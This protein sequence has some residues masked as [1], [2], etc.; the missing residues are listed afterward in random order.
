MRKIKTLI[1][2]TAVI[3]MTAA[4]LVSAAPSPVAGTVTVIVPG[5]A[6]EKPA[7]VKTPTEKELKE[8]AEFISENA[9][10]LGMSASVKSTID[11]VAP[12]DYKGGDT[13][14]VFAVSGLKDGAKNV[15]AYILLKNGK[16]IIVPCTIKNGYVG[17]I[18]PAFG[19]VSIVE[20]NPAA[21]MA[22]STTSAAAAAVA[23]S[24]LH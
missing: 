4:T 6:G 11:I 12:A 17:F 18:A 3:A 20:L 24:T 8:L 14:V 1:A 21:Q 22:G 10:A 9:A 15:F 19:T 7:E 23:L 13:P 2:L 5:S 16:R